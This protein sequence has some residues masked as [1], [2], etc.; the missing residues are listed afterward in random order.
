MW[1]CAGTAVRRCY[2]VY[3][4]VHKFKASK[5]QNEMKYIFGKRMHK[6]LIL[7]FINRRGSSKKDDR[8][9]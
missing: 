4:R 5:I 6:T 3:L 8:N 1:N 7:I 2:V 9:I